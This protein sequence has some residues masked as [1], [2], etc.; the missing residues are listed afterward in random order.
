MSKVPLQ[1]P[2]RSP[3]D[4]S[5]LPWSPWPVE[6]LQPIA[7]AINAWSTSVNAAM[8]TLSHEWLSFVDRRLQADL[9]LQHE[10]SA[11]RHPDEVWR[12]S[13]A[14]CQKT[15]DQY[16]SELAELARIGN[17]VAGENIAALRQSIET[18]ARE[19]R[20]PS[21]V[22]AEMPRARAH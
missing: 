22:A 11:C 13:A 21:S 17:G 16:Q 6:A 12:V 9:A 19:K 5:P 10:L 20:Q 3:S 7:A 1:T 2:P 8:I 4:P 15:L 18:T 14:F